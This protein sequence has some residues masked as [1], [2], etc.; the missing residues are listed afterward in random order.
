MHDSIDNLI[1]MNKSMLGKKTEEFDPNLV[2]NMNTSQFN[3]ANSQT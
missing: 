2:N 1:K 3:L